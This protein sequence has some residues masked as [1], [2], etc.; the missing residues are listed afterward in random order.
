M[1]A[2]LSISMYCSCLRSTSVRVRSN[3]SHQN[4]SANCTCAAARSFNSLIMIP[5]DRR[6]PFSAKPSLS[7][8]AIHRPIREMSST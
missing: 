7:S 2:S 6:K 1:D 4:P 3:E 5:K 8:A